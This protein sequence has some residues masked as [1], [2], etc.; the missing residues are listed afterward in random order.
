MLR[1]VLFLVLIALAGAGAAWVA[2]QP[3]EV[4]MTWGGWRAS[5]TIPVFV[6]LLGIFAVAIVLLWSLLTATWR[7]PGRMRRRRHEKRHARG[8]HAITHGLLA[9]GHGD[10]ALARRHADTARRLAA[11]DPLALLLHAQ[12]AQLEGN[13]D[14]AQRVFRVMAEREDTRLLGLRGLFIEAQR[15]DD[16]VGAVMIAE[17]AI[18]LSP[19]STWAS[20]A[21]L[22]FRCARGDWSGALA[23]LDSNLS[24]GL[25]DKAAYRR[26]RGV[27]LTARALELETMDRDVA[28]ESVM[29]AI[30]LAPTLVP[31]AVLAAKFESEAHQVRRAMKMVEAAW[32]ANPHPDL[33][34]AYAHVKLGDSARQRLQRVETLAAKT[35]DKTAVDRPGHVEGQLAIARA[36][37]DASEFAR[38]RDVLAPYVNDP[39]QRVALLMA[40]IERTEHGDG[41]RARA[42]TLRAVRARHDPAWTADGYVSDRWRPVS[43]VTGRLDAFQWQTPVASLPSGKGATIESSAFEEAMLA[44]PPPKRVT[45]APSEA[46]VEPV[47]TTPAP[48]PAAQDNS[49][50]EAEAK[51]AG[52]EAAKETVEE[53]VKE[54]PAVALAEPVAPAPEAAESSPVAATPVFRTR[55][56]LGKPAQAPI[57]AVIPIVRAPDD[58]GIDDEGPS[59]EFTEQIGTPAHAKAQ[60]GGWRGFWSRW[61]A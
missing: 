52:K 43:P 30:K 38:A 6:L 33:A 61:G 31:A 25:I 4:V 45:A 50:P 47:A 34:D 8:R 26:Q 17:E 20:H 40:E 42:W 10:T 23:I 15:A 16:A 37:I 44:A 55:A 22:G 12:S 5:P 7:L 28:R 36:A 19:S 39:T 49:P 13:R 18:K 1:I 48:V 60:A 27:L 57:Q 41:G 54:E 21:V 58:P 32:L 24:A 3:G 56:D 11:N 46:P 14:E 51:E 53:I 29:E 59:D 2:D 35:N 9:I